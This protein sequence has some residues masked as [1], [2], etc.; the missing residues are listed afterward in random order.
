MKTLHLR[1]AQLGQ[2]EGIDKI[3][4]AAQNSFDPRL[5][6]ARGGESKNSALPEILTLALCHRNIELIF[7]P[8]LNA[9]QH[10]PLA[11]K[12]VVL[13]NHQLKLKHSHHHEL[14]L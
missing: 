13:G 8:A 9:F 11:L 1:V 12:R 6:C 14:A 3:D 7:H 4:D 2:S 10:P 5:R